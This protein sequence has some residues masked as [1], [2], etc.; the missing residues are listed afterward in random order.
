[1]ENQSNSSLKK[2]YPPLRIFLDSF[3]C[4]KWKSLFPDSDDFL[5]SPEVALSQVA[6]HSD[7]SYLHFCWTAGENHNLKILPRQ[8]NVHNILNL[9]R[10]SDLHTSGI[11]HLSEKSTRQK[12]L[13]KTVEKKLTENNLLKNFNKLE[14]LQLQLAKEDNISN[15]PHILLQQPFFKNYEAAQILLHEKGSKEAILIKTTPSH[16][17]DIFIT[18]TATFTRIFNSIKK[19]KF[20]QFDSK[21]FEN[22]EKEFTQNFLGTYLA[23]DM[24]L[25]NHNLI[26]MLSRNEFLSIQEDEK[27]QFI[28]I[29]SELKPIIESF[30]NKASQKRKSQILEAA[31]NLVPQ[32]IEIACEKD[33]EIV[34]RNSY[35]QDNINDSQKQT[36]N[37]IIKLENAKSLILYNKEDD[38]SDNPEIM[39]QQ[40]I[41][42][43]GELFNTLKHEL[44]N[45]LFGIQLSLEL[46][47]EEEGFWQQFPEEKIMISDM[48]AGVKKCQT[49][50]ENFSRLYTPLDRHIEVDIRDLINEILILAKSEIKLINK[51]LLFCGFE[52]EEDFILMSNPTYLAQI[53]FNL[54]INSAQAMKNKHFVSPIRPEI[55]ILVTHCNNRIEIEINDNGPGISQLA[56][57]KLFDPF[58]TTKKQGTGLGLSICKKL[59]KHLKGEINYQG[60]GPLEGASFLLSLPI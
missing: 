35:L 22:C 53:L 18:D 36:I 13:L 4:S 23:I 34:F 47:G 16:E 42:L 45:P 51:D 50:I 38:F 26:L 39:H 57:D 40:R 58:F 49:I 60:V 54:I 28:S 7:Q 14:K 52:H 17:E 32:G 48:K 46:L 41:I 59:A 43:L 8:S 2:K 25:S 37:R 33:N 21:L 15:L 1:V 56:Q 6:V 27:K 29:T 55:A 31:I 24:N 11:H 5:Y 3:T 10:N 30:I 12:S 20:K 19:S 9:L 44:S